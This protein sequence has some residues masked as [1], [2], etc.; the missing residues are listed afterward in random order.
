M[1]LENKKKF[2]AKVLGVGAG[3]II[4]NKNRLDEIKEAMTRQDMRDLF[5]D[6]DVSVREIK[7]RRAIKK[8]KTRR[9]AGSRRQP[10]FD[11]K[12]KYMI[13]SRKLRSYL[14]ELRKNEKLTEEH[15]QM[16]RKEIKASS[17]RD[18]THLKERI[19]LLGV[20]Q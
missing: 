10:V 15:F 5:A 12:G 14:S 18:K 17:F 7:G 13:I 8:R 6:G 11:T 9:R 1:K 16:L 2:A 20:K 4:F 19:K 3:R